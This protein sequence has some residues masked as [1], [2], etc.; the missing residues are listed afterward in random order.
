[1]GVGV[2]TCSCW[3]TTSSYVL[4]DAWW[5]YA[6]YDFA[7]SD[8]NGSVRSI[9]EDGKRERAQ[10]HSAGGDGEDNEKGVPVAVGAR[11]RGLLASCQTRAPLTSGCLPDPVLASDTGRCAR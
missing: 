4:C 3:R 5:W 10:V 8:L 1:M 9:E 6:P 11:R 7:T 2:D